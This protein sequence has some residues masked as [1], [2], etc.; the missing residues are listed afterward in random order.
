MVT[1][2]SKWFLT[3]KIL[4]LYLPLRQQGSRHFNKRLG[5]IKHTAWNKLN[6]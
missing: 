1:I 6:S 2:L 5:E 4:G 3:V